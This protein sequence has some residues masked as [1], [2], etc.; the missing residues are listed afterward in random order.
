MAT[1][2]DFQ[3]EIFIRC[4]YNSIHRIPQRRFANHISVC[5]SK[6]FVKFRICPYNASHRVEPND[7][8]EHIFRCPDNK[9]LIRQIY[10][11]FRLKME[12]GQSFIYKKVEKS[13]PNTHEVKNS[14]NKGRSKFTT[15]LNDDWNSGTEKSFRLADA[16]PV[17]FKNVQNNIRKTKLLPSR[18]ILKKLSREQR[19]NCYQL[20]VD[21]TRESRLE[22]SSI[23]STGSSA[24][25]EFSQ[26]E[27]PSSSEYFTAESE[28]ELPEMVLSTIK[29]AKK[30]SYSNKWQTR[31]LNNQNQVNKQKFIDDLNNS[32]FLTKS[33]SNVID[34]KKPVEQEKKKESKL[35]KLKRVLQNFNE[36]IKSHIKSEKI[37]SH[38]SEKV[39]QKQ[40][41]SS[42]RDDQNT[43]ERKYVGYRPLR[44]PNSSLFIGRMAAY[45]PSFN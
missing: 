24:E 18:L 33:E 29:P 38:M 31:S 43:E 7:Y 16:E 14:R 19:L 5:P 8:K 17:N 37:K 3:N 28:L 9:H 12:T 26:S 35:A 13:N 45:N 22:T 11:E 44:R 36:K 41:K 40:E 25:S 2:E 15:D 27:T 1:F 39:G 34:Q 6:K 42:L 21:L 4:P 10:E 20:Y 30:P 23:N 32:N